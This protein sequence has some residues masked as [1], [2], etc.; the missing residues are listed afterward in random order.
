VWPITTPDRGGYGDAHLGRISGPGLAARLG[1]AFV[2]RG[3]C[4][5]RLRGG[6]APDRKHGYERVSTVDGALLRGGSNLGS[7]LC[8][9]ARKCDIIWITLSEEVLEEQQ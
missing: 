9:S 6:V 8:G 7:P 3:Q 4:G 1:P 2:P 5:G